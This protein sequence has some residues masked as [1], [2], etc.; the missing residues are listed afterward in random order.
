MRIYHYTELRKNLAT[1]LNGIEDDAEPVAITRA[2]HEPVV[3]ITQALYDSLTET[4]FVLGDRDQTRALLDAIA[5][6]EAGENMRHTTVEELDE[7]AALA[8]ARV[9][10]RGAAA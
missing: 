6:T 4:E 8:A 1:I 7:L 5:E 3:I 10:Q 2:G 9:E